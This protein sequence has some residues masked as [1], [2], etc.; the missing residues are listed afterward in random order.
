MLSDFTNH[1]VSV[2]EETSAQ[3]CAELPTDRFDPQHDMAEGDDQEQSAEGD[4]PTMDVEAARDDHDTDEDG[5]FVQ[6]LGE[7][8]AFN[9]LIDLTQESEAESDARALRVS[10]LPPEESD[11]EI[12][13]EDSPP[14]STPPGAL[15]AASAT[16]ARKRKN[17]AQS[18]AGAAAKKPKASAAPTAGRTKEPTAEDEAL[19][20]ILEDLLQNQDPFAAGQEMADMPVLDGFNATTVKDQERLFRELSSKDPHA[21]KR[22][23]RGDLVML[24][25]ARKLLAGKYKVAGEKYAIKGM[26]TPLFAYQFAA[27]GW[28]VGREE[29]TE[30]PQGGILADAMGLGKTVETLACIV[31]N[32]PSEEDVGSGLVTTL[33]VVPANAVG[34]W[35]EEIRKHGNNIMVYHYKRS[36]V[37]NQAMREYSPIW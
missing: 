28:M 2:S 1:P 8:R 21:D 4:S 35:I 34:E 3:H 37:I 36:D 30:A 33:V 32:P 7:I 31:G 10:L 18:G 12:K 6:Q 27:V 13:Q 25:R 26:K 9:N 11:P 17:T 29:S 24:A 14:L 16:N 5:L 23:T 15:V 20:L 22:K 19:K